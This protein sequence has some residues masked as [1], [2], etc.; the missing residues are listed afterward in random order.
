[1]VQHVVVAGCGDAG[2]EAATRLDRQLA[3]EITVVC[4][5]ASKPFYFLFYHVLEGK[6][7]EDAYLDLNAKFETKNIRFIQ[8]RIEGV[9]TVNH[10][11]ELNTGLL[12]FDKLVIAVGSVPKQH[13]RGQEHILS[14]KTD[15]E[16]IVSQLEQSDTIENI[17]I[18]GGGPTG[19][20]TAAT[21]SIVVE[22]S[23]TI[24]ES[25]ARLLPTF[26]QKTGEIAESILRSKDVRIPTQT[27][28]V[29]ATTESVILEDSTTL[30]SD[31]TI[32]AGGIKPNPIIQHA[33]LASTDRGLVVDE[34]LRCR[35]NPDIY[36]A[37][38]VIN[39]PQKINDGYSAVLEAR[40]AANNLTCSLRGQELSAYTIPVHPRL[41]YLGRG[42]AI[43][44]INGVV[45]RGL[46]PGLIRTWGAGKLYPFLW[47][48]VL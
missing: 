17:V 16:I 4:D 42:D 23:I 7:F 45:W 24:L 3:Q 28:A 26:A 30:R 48:H 19:V 33:D 31:L 5:R 11:L 38:D 35:G 27:G 13:L 29:A 6:P 41:V 15:I 1:M 8:A 46:I 37:G 20:E 14:I 32:W 10:Q 9:D 18:L 43:L 40:T 44:E 39:Y 47:R 25:G 2:L 22:S 21:L 12:D 34:T 36:A